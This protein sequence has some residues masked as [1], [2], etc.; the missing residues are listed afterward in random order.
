MQKKPGSRYIFY[1]L[2]YNESLMILGKLPF[3]NTRSIN[4]I[5]QIRLINYQIFSSQF[6]FRH[7][8]IDTKRI[9]DWCV[10]ISFPKFD[11]PEKYLNLLLNWW[12]SVQKFKRKRFFFLSIFL[13]T[14]LNVEYC[15]THR[16]HT[17]GDF[18][19]ILAKLVLWN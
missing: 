8:V 2:I 18:I 5:I 16:L 4:I 3:F 12:R 7:F 9:H 11:A 10:M 15:N 14:H 17:N 13:S 6:K 19:L 1:V